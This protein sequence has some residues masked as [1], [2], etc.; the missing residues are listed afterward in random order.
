MSDPTPDPVDPAADAPTA[1]PSFR[2]ANQR[3]RD[4]QRLAGVHPYQAQKVLR[5]LDAMEILG[6]PM[7]VVVG[8]R[9]DAEQAALYAQGRTEPGPNARPGHPLGDTV[10]NADGRA[11][12]IGGTGK[13][14]HQKQSDGYGHAVDCAFLDDPLTVKIETWDAHQPWAVYGT[15]G[16]AFGLTW[17]GRWVS[18]IDRPHL[19]LATGSPFSV[20]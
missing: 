10:T 20:L 18:L 6:V 8:L 17:G 4:A 19:E 5:I 2:T 14:M 9:S 15:M 3:S 11:R 12:A 16:E 1:I 7:F 13:S